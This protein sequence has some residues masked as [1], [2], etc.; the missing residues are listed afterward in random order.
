MAQTLPCVCVWVC[1]SR[2][3]RERAMRIWAGVCCCTVPHSRNTGS[4][5]FLHFFVVVVCCCCFRSTTHL[6]QSSIRYMNVCRVLNVLCSVVPSS[7]LVS[8]DV[9][10]FKWSLLNWIVRRR[11]ECVFAVII[12]FVADVTWTWTHRNP[13]NFFLFF[14]FVSH[15]ISGNSRRSTCVCV[16]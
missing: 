3:E 5:F 16:A 12:L 4:F 11:S 9:V 14:P 6:L 13:N 15:R 7:L 2:S 10:R 1:V 8:S